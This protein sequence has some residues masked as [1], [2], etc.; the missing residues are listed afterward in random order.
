ML[1]YIYSI[2]YIYIYIT[3]F[4]IGPPSLHA[5]GTPLCQALLWEVLWFPPTHGLGDDSPQLPWPGQTRSRDRDRSWDRVPNP[6]PFLRVVR[7]S[8]DFRHESVAWHSVQNGAFSLTEAK[9][10]RRLDSSGS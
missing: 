4:V 1:T 10:P 8:A 7:C 5:F 2:I 9:P 3:L 6:N